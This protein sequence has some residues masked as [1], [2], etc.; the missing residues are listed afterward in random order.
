MVAHAWNLSALKAEPGGLG[1]QAYVQLGSEC[2][3]R[4]CVKQTKKKA[5]E[6]N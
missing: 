3:T 4:D 5:R 6:Q 2:D 1:L